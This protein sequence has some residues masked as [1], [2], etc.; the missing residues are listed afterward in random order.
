[1][2]LLRSYVNMASSEELKTKSN[3][4]ESPEQQ[5]KRVWSTVCAHNHSACPLDSNCSNRKWTSYDA[6]MSDVA[7][8]DYYSPLTC[9][10]DLHA[11]KMNG[12]ALCSFGVAICCKMQLIPCPSDQ[13]PYAGLLMPETTLDYCII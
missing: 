6:V 4:E 7:N 2:L 12:K 1:M 13:E 5:Q 11:T 3:D 8:S 10:H 9:P